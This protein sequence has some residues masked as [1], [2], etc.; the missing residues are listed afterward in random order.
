VTLNV[1]PR[2]N[3]FSSKSVPRTSLG[4][5][6]I[7]MISHS[8]RTLTVQAPGSIFKVPG[9]KFRDGKGDVEH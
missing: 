1:F 7:V 2:F 5:P 8:L 3:A 9:L 4:S 6:F